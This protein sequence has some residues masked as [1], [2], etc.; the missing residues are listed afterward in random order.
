[1]STV[2]LLPRDRAEAADTWR[3]RACSAVPPLSPAAPA[4]CPA[5][6]CVEAVCLAALPGLLRALWSDSGGE[7]EGLPRRL[8]YRAWRA[9]S[10]ST[11]SW[12]ASAVAGSCS[13]SSRT[14]S[15]PLLP[16]RELLPLEPFEPGCKLP[17]LSPSVPAA[18]VPPRLA[19]RRRQYSSQS[20]S[21]AAPA[22]GLGAQRECTRRGT[23]SSSMHASMHHRQAFCKLLPRVEA[24]SLAWRGR[25]SAAQPSTCAQ[26]STAQH[27]TA[28][29]SPAHY[30]TA[31]HGTAGHPPTHTPAITPP[32]TA[33][34]GVPPLPDELVAAVPAGLAAAAG[35]RARGGGGGGGAG[36][37]GFSCHSSSSHLRE[38]R[39]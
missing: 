28:Q 12:K 31:Q 18:A 8:R 2:P 15:D 26:H 29:P 19:T 25:S 23:S 34:T 33:P 35:D 30:S 36:A 3:A 39:R 7:P 1:M 17:P 10:P 37:G 4:F 9:L 27:S 16:R 24:R 38:A 11:F 22:D 13:V 14:G 32:T 20:A 5:A 21:P 6:S